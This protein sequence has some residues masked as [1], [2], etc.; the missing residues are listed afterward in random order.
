MGVKMFPK[1]QIRGLVS[2]GVDGGGKSRVVFLE[3]D[4]GLATWLHQI[5]SGQKQVT[6]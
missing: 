4:E 5:R 2:G 3:A 1:I 6:S